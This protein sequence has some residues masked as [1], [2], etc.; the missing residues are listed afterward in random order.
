MKLN[1]RG[2]KIKMQIQKKRDYK[3]MM[4]I[5]HDFAR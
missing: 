5:S 4:V 1:R 3:L 2:E